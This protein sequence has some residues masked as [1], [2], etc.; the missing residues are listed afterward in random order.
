M[1]AQIISSSSR[2]AG[3]PRWERTVHSV[4]RMS[5]CDF[6]VEISVIFHFNDRSL[7]LTVPQPNHCLLFTFINRKENVTIS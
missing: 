1:C 2:V 6:L 3:L 7:V 5:L 4:S